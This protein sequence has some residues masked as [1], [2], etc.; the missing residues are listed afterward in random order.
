MASPTLTLLLDL[1]W[2]ATAMAGWP[3][4]GILSQVALHKV[5]VLQGMLQSDALDGLDDQ[6]SRTYFGEVTKA[7]E[8]GDLVA[9]FQASAKYLQVCGTGPASVLGQLTAMATQVAVQTDVKQRMD[10][11]QAL[12]K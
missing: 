2:L 11:I 8:T 9:M 7:S 10:S 4:F 3:F 12:Q 6:I 1:P 5:N